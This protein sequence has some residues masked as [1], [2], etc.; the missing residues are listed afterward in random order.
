MATNSKGGSLL[1][2]LLGWLCCASVAPAAARR[3]YSWEQRPQKDYWVIARVRRW[4]AA[5][6]AQVRSSAETPA[7]W[8]SPPATGIFTGSTYDFRR[9]DA[10]LY[11][12][13]LE[14]Q[15]VRGL[16]F[17]FETGDNKFK[18]GRYF[19]H[20]WLHAPNRTVYLLN[21][22]TW[23]D[24]QHRDYAKKQMETSGSARQYSAA[25]YLN[26]YRTD[27]YGQDGFCELA[28]SLDVFLG[29]SYYETRVRLFNGYKTLSTDFFLPTDP[30][31][32]MTGLDSSAR[33]A[34]YGWTG[35]F[36]ERADLGRGFTAEARFSFGPTMK[37]RGRNY[38]NLDS[39][40]A[41]PGVRNAA[42]GT[43]AEFDISGS[44]KFWK[45][46]ELNGGW[47]LSS[48][49][50]SSGSETRYYA[51]GTTG[52]A[53]LSRVKATRKGFTFGISWKY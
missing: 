31:G 19:E 39:T 41:N 14:T 34:W 23:T 46:F 35:G 36:R 3:Y 51:D 7:S 1:A 21:G 44:Y 8:W 18:D 4:Q 40:L 33:M 15:P 29:Y 12:F 32:P 16:S 22:V 28:H 50:A 43:L 48:C 47:M 10:P 42:T 11:L 30:V 24:P 20:D 37:F 45:N 27:G 38:W 25:A 17:G 5:T 13:S 6:S 2:A 52:Q 26:I 53:A 49:N 9:L